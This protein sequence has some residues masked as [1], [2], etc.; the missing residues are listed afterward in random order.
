[1]TAGRP[2]PL[3]HVGA[4]SAIF[5]GNAPRQRGRSRQ[6]TGYP[7]F[8]PCVGRDTP[9]TAKLMTDTAMLSGLYGILVICS[10]SVGLWPG[11]LPAQR[12][13]L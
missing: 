1:M 13:Y 8:A 9:E 6:L 3:A 5:T 7:R 11:E 4:L 12:R 2:K 10:S